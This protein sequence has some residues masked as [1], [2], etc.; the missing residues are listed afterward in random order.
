MTCE[1]RLPSSSRGPYSFTQ[2]KFSPDGN[3]LAASSFRPGVFLWNTSSGKRLQVLR[4]PKGNIGA[5]AFSKD[6]KSLVTAAGSLGKGTRITIGTLDLATGKETR[7]LHVRPRVK[8][9]ADPKALFR[10]RVAFSPDG[11]KIACAHHD[12]SFEMWDVATGKRRLTIPGPY[13]RGEFFIAAKGKILVSLTC[14]QFPKNIESLTNSETLK[15]L[16]SQPKK[17]FAFIPQ[18]LSPLQRG[19]LV[20]PMGKPWRHLRAAEVHCSV[21]GIW[22]RENDCVSSPFRQVKSATL[23]FLQM[24]GCW[25]P[26]VQVERFAC[27]T[28]KR[29]KLSGPFADIAAGLNYWSF[30][31]MD[32]ALP[33]RARTAPY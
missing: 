25:H 7:Q 29:A 1:K 3:M 17:Q 20:R 5:F 26:V 8:V 24:D 22:A 14:K 28:W 2:M 11:T 23:H 19:M 18:S 12:G 21:F 27:G 4:K 6:G 31:R 32:A 13:Y 9:A 30:R 10:G 15:V 33:H 16:T